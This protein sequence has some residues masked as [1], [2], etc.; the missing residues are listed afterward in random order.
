MERKKVLERY[1]LKK[2]P[3]Y[4]NEFAIWKNDMQLMLNNVF[5]SLNREN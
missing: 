2:A 5:M 3:K 4:Q 1:H